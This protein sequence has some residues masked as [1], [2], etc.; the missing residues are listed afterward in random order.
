MLINTCVYNTE[1]RANMTLG[2]YS[3]HEEMC[4]NYLHYYPAGELEVCKSSV[5]DS[6]LSDYFE[7][8][9]YYDQAE[10]SNEKS[11]KENFNAVRWTPLTAEILEKLYDMADISFS[12]NSSDGVNIERIYAQQNAKRKE[13][14]KVNIPINLSTK[15]APVD[16]ELSGN[17]DHNEQS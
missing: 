5:S 8:M 15:H 6:E 10:T 13:S 3:I 9:K 14:F 11:V 17:C 16:Y 2:G 4:V 12:C 7:K 1:T